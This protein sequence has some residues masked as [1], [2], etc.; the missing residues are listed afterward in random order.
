MDGLKRTWARA[1]A[2]LT[3]AGEEITAKELA[4]VAGLACVAHGAAQF[5]AG[6][7][8]LAAGVVLLA[9]VAFSYRRPKPPPRRDAS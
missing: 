7:G 4:A 6:A 8:W 5:H 2:R 3:D 9:A 1:R